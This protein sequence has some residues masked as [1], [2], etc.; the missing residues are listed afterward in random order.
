MRR[1]APALLPPSAGLRPANAPER[2]GDRRSQERSLIAVPLALGS[3]V[4]PLGVG[5]VPTDRTP[6][7]RPALPTR[8]NRPSRPGA[9]R[10]HPDG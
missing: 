6:P 4:V 7:V 1:R 3:K 5:P 10:G 2:T 8:P 9:H